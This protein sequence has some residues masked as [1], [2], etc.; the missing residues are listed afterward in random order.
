MASWRLTNTRVTPTSRTRFPTPWTGMM[1]TTTTR[2]TGGRAARPWIPGASGVRPRARQARRP[3]RRRVPREFWLSAVL[4][5]PTLIWGHLLQ[6]AFG[7][8]APMF[9]GS[10]W[11]PAVCGTG[12]FACGG[13]PFLEWA[14]RA[15]SRSG[16]RGWW[17]AGYNVVAIPLA[18][19]VQ[20][21]PGVV[22][23]PAAGDVLMSVRT[24]IVAANAQLLR[25]APLT[26][27]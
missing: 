2:C 22:L 4:T 13:W 25:R 10:A 20:A 26:L 1:R 24:I 15:R 6:R 3:Q 5:A 11:I 27:R 12:V 21:P 17:A 7:F 8:R 23:S 9:T 16:S 18:A 14:R 19:G